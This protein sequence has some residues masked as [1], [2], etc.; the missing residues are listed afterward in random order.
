[1]KLSAGSESCRSLD[2]PRWDVPEGEITHVA[3]ARLDIPLHIY[4]IDENLFLVLLLDPLP[5]YYRF[6]LQVPVV[7]I[8]DAVSG[9]SCDIAWGGY[10]GDTSYRNPSDSLGPGF[11][12]KKFPRIFRPL[13]FFLKVR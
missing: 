13:A 10:P 2:I 3:P 9:V 4:E 12:A 1:M 8:T 11:F 6:R 5:R 7:S